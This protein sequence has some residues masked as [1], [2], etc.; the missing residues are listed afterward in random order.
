M[1]SITKTFWQNIDSDKFTAIALL[2]IGIIAGFE[3]GFGQA[4]IQ[5]LACGFLAGILEIIA[6]WLTTKEWKITYAGVVW[7]L[8]VALNIPPDRLTHALVAAFLVVVLKEAFKGV[9]KL[10]DQTLFHPAALSLVLVARWGG[11]NLNVWGNGLLIM[12]LVLALGA[13]NTI[14]NQRVVQV[15]TALIVFAALDFFVKRSITFVGSSPLG[16]VLSTMPWFF[17]LFFV[18]DRKSSLPKISAQIMFGAIV[19]LLAIGFRSTPL[20]DFT[21]FYAL[22]VAN[23]CVAILVI[24]EETKP[25]GKRVKVT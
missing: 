11:L 2:A 14:K 19:A 3:F 1:L 12:I 4:I 15:M 6:N 17:L 5:L 18:A 22:L 13:L 25:I 21:L 8:L 10:G 20:K 24:W 23:L 16:N 9:V 7:G